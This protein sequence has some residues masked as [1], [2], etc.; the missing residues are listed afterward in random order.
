ML[1]RLTLLL[2]FVIA[3][4]APPGFAADIVITAGVDDNFALPADPA[5]PSAALLALPMTFQNFD[6]I[7]GVNGL[8]DRNVAHTFT[9][10]P[11]NIQGASLELRVRAGNDAGVNTDGLL[12]SFVDELT[13]VYCGGAVVYART[14]G[15]FAGGGCFPTA[16]ATGLVGSWAVGQT[17]TILLDLSDLPLAGGGGVSVIPEMNSRGFIDVNVSD[18]TGCDFMRLSIDTTQ[19]T[20][21]PPRAASVAV[22][23]RPV[24]NPF[25]PTTTFRFEL[26]ESAQ[27]E[28]AIYDTAGRRVRTLVA[29]ERPRG[30]SEVQW[31]GRDDRG[32]PAASG[33]YLG[34]LRVGP[35]R[36]TT[37]AVLLK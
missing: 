13:T 15:P 12:I 18:E 23:H 37:K 16:D 25:N 11:A 35:H 8:A 30:T 31:D 7:A 2:S 3:S 17:A 14:F 28:F 5:S 24:P 1:T 20:S 26:V 9:G 36:L 19:A 6:L 29:G 21:V 22:L 27:V 10:L 4:T 32:V 33:V 34:S